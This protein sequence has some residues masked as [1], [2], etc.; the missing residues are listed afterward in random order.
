MSRNDVESAE[1]TLLACSLTA[2]TTKGLSDLNFSNLAVSATALSTR[3]TARISVS[4]S[5]KPAATLVVVSL[6]NIE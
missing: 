2:S 4:Y 5:R 3:R 6:R 1:N